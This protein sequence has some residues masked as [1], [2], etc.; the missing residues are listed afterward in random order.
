MSFDWVSP[1]LAVSELPICS[2]ISDVCVSQYPISTIIFP[3]Y[4][5]FIRTDTLCP[6]NLCDYQKFKVP[7]TK[8]IKLYSHISVNQVS[9]QTFQKIYIPVANVNLPSLHCC[10]GKDFQVS[11]RFGQEN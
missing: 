11:P 9:S 1:A 6:Q 10:I 7:V 5:P 3:L 8:F 4:L 2:L